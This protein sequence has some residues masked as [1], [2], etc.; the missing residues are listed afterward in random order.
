[1]AWPCAPADA[2]VAKVVAA[3]PSTAMVVVIAARVSLDAWCTM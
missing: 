3:M 1:V 2:G